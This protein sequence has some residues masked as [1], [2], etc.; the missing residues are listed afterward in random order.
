MTKNLP[1]LKATTPKN[2]AKANKFAVVQYAMDMVLKVGLFP[3]QVSCF[4]P[5]TR[6]A[7]YKGWTIK[8]TP[9]SETASLRSSVFKGFA[10][11]LVF[12]IAC[13]YC[14]NVQHDGCIR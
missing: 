13:M 8:P 14:D 6:H 5:M 2:E 4:D 12:L 7:M 1:A 11:E 9:K 3:V 10:N